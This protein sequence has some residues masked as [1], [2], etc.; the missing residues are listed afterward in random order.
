MINTYTTYIYVEAMSL[1]PLTQVHKFN[2]EINGPFEDYFRENN[3]IYIKMC[4]DE[5]IIY[6]SFLE[7]MSREFWCVLRMN[8]GKDK[9][10]I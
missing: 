8:Y 9:N 2:N 3:N 5:D 4:M 1:L 7:E 10:D 6:I